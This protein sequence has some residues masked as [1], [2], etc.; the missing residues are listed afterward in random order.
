ME[1]G[2]TKVPPPGRAYYQSN[3]QEPNRPPPPYGKPM[4]YGMDNRGMKYEVDGNANNNNN[5][6]NND[7]SNNNEGI[8]QWRF[9]AYL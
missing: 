7:D 9:T 5:N 4:N 1:E 2:F 3:G 6:N 8:L